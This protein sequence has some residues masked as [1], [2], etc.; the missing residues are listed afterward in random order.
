MVARA[1]YR[2]ARTVELLSTGFC[3]P[4]TG[5]YLMATTVQVSDHPWTAY[6]KNSA[7]RLAPRN[8]ANLVLHGRSGNW[9]ATAQS[10]LQ[11]VARHGGV[12]HLWGHS[13]EIEA[14]QQWSQ[15]E[16]ILREMSALRTAVPCITNSAVARLKPVDVIHTAP[17]RCDT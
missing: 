2:C 6:A 10:M 5:I 4:T 8:L 12:F 9:Q 14:A 11:S 7:K 1:G 3:K 13:W 16:A 17:A 15:L